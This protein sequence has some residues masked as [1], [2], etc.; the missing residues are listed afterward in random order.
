MLYKKITVV[1]IKYESI[2][3]SILIIFEKWK[4][5]PMDNSN[6]TLAT[7]LTLKNGQTIKNRFMK[8]A[9]SEQLGDKYHNPKK[10]LSV[11]FQTWANNEVGLLVTGNIMVDRTAIGEP[12]NVVLDE[13]SD[14][15]KFR[16][17][18]Q[19]ATVNDVQCWA[20]LNHPGKQSPIYLSRTPVAPSAI[21]L[22]L[23]ALSSAFGKPRALTDAEIWK[24][25]DK[26]ATSAKLAK[27][28]GFTG[29]Q[30]HGAHGYLVSQFLSP[31]HNQRTDAWGG[32][33]EK[34]MKF[35]LE[36]YKAM[37]ASVGDDFPIGIKLNS[38]DFQK[39]GFSET[40][41]MAVIIKLTE[42]GIDHVEV[43]G[44]TY[45]SQAMMGNKKSLG[46]GKPLKEST[47]KREAYFLNYAEKLREVTDVPL[48]VTGGFRSTKGMQEALDDGA[49]DMIGIA[50]PLLVYPD[51]CIK[52]MRNP[53]YVAY[54]DEPTT[55]F[56]FV[57][58][59]A[60]LSITWYEDQIHRLG[61]GQKPKPSLNAWG[62]VARMYAK[63]GKKA[64]KQ[65][66]A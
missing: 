27:Q 54:F 19:A 61:N 46:N 26:F 13:Q 56:K 51:F 11:A 43:S 28:V 57:D 29:V 24:I 38:A 50:R 60:M 44:G 14:L 47:K 31:S 52:A 42:L 63:L 45:E 66:R 53:S 3:D 10:A 21:P 64:F 9:T 15:S 34:R 32:S 40:S 20:Q 59:A 18:A 36:I 39:A 6:I 33:D 22:K 37:R 30:I 4:N 58:E 2:I 25:I 49:T 16:A 65:R 48:T 35:V 62:T 41:S 12:N 5:L 55:G 17:W 23:G 8:S 1:T 7:P